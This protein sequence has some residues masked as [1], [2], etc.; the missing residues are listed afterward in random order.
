MMNKVSGF[1]VTRLVA[2]PIHCCKIRIGLPSLRVIGP[3]QSR[4]LLGSGKAGQDGNQPRQSKKPKPHWFRDDETEIQKQLKL[5]ESELGEAEKEPFGKYRGRDAIMR[6]LRER[7]PSKNKRRHINTNVAMA[8]INM[9]IYIR[10]ALENGRLSMHLMCQKA[11]GESFFGPGTKIRIDRASAQKIVKNLWRYGK[12]DQ[13]EHLRKQHETN[14][15]VKQY[16]KEKR[17]EAELRKQH[18]AKE[19]VR[20]YHEEKRKEAELKKEKEVLL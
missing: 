15:E 4:R 16:H 9:L 8:R 13:L 3:E 18:E 7:A 6:I 14:E 11:L 19:E 17:K 5:I 2:G 10:H 12:C 20:R 1:L